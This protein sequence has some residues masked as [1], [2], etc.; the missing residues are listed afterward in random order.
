M[1]AI[2]Y[3]L[4]PFPL[5]DLPYEQLKYNSQRVRQL[6]NEKKIIC[7]HFVWVLFITVFQLSCHAPPLRLPPLPLSALVILHCAALWRPRIEFNCLVSHEREGGRRRERYICIYRRREREKAVAETVF[8]LLLF[9]DSLKL[10]LN[11]IIIYAFGRSVN[12]SR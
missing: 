9:N 4:P 1:V 3:P 10:L 12:K 8:V 11:S 2:P 5:R 6:N 7:M